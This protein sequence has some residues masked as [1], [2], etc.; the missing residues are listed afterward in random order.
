MMTLTMKN[1][2]QPIQQFITAANTSADTSKKP[3]AKN[4]IFH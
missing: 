2:L 3:S 4:E 1:A